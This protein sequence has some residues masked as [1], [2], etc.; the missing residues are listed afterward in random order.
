LRRLRPDRS[1]GARERQNRSRDTG[2]KPHPSHATM[3][4]G[5]MTESGAERNDSAIRDGTV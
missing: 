4:G 1:A 3:V 2:R 5:P